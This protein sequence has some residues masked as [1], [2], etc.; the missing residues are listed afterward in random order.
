[1]E[2]V[3]SLSVTIKPEQEASGLTPLVG[4]WESGVDIKVTNLS[5]IAK[6]PKRRITKTAKVTKGLALQSKFNEG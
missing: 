3:I 2:K 1:M 6:G 4:H 5:K